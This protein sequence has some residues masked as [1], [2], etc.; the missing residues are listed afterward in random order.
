M[1][2]FHLMG[3]VFLGA[4]IIGIF[5]PIL[6]TTPFVLLAAACFARSSEKWH[7]WLLNN[8]TF[9]PMIH[10]WEENRC[11]PCRIKLIAVIS[12]ALVGGSSIYFAVETSQGRM[13][14][15]LFILV[16]LVTISLIKTCQK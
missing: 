2:I 16:G 7:R 14:G 9:G 5:L 8:R 4:A 3:F 13:I 12:M 10:D 15:G 6:P 11:I 1:N